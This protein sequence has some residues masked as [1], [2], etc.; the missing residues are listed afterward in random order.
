[1]TD[2]HS[3][4]KVYAPENMRGYRMASPAFNGIHNKIYRWLPKMDVEAMET[5]RPNWCVA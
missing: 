2:F 1:L 4:I 5:N 3:V